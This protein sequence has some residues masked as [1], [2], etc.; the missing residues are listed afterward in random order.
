MADRSKY[1][2]MPR[3]VLPTAKGVAAKDDR[4]Y[5]EAD[6]GSSIPKEVNSKT[7]TKKGGSR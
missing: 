2:P 3:G 1:K 5:V 6:S 7:K 4:R